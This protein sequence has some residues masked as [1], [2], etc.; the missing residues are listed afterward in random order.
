MSVV[1]EIKKGS[2][3]IKAAQLDR[4]TDISGRYFAEYNSS[5]GECKNPVAEPITNIVIT[6]NSTKVNADPD[7][8]NDYV[9]IEYI[10][11]KN[12]QYIDTGIGSFQDI[13]VTYQLVGDISEQKQYAKLLYNQAYPL[14][15]TYGVEVRTDSKTFT[16]VNNTN[17]IS[18]AYNN[19]KTNL[20]L[21]YRVKE[22]N[23]LELKLKWTIGASS[24]TANIRVYNVKFTNNADTLNGTAGKIDGDF[25]PVIR[26]S[27]NKPGM[28][29]KVSKQ[30]FVNQGT[31]EFVTGPELPGKILEVD[32]LT[33][34]G[35]NLL[36]ESL[37]KAGSNVGVNWTKEGNAIIIN[38]STTSQ[39][40]LIFTNV[41]DNIFDPNK[42][43][44][45]S[46]RVIG[47]TAIMGKGT[48]ITYSWALFNTA[49]TKYARNSIW[50]SKESLINE[51]IASTFRSFKGNLFNNDD[52]LYIMLQSWRVGTTF[53]NLK[54]VFQIEEAS[55]PSIY[56][57]YQQPE[58][59]DL[60]PIHGIG[61]L[62]DK[63]E[64]TR[65][66]EYNQLVKNGNLVENTNWYDNNSTHKINNSV[67]EST[68]TA[69]HGG[70]MQD[71]DA[72]KYREHKML[73]MLEGMIESN[74]NGSYFGIC[75]NDNFSQSV[76]PMPEK[77]NKWQ[78]LYAFGTI[79]KNANSS[80]TPLVKIQDPRSSN[81]TKRYARNIRVIDLTKLF[82][83]GNEPTT[84]E[85]FYS[86][87]IGKLIQKGVYLPYSETN[88]RISKVTR[89]R[90]ANKIDLGTFDYNL[91]TLDGNPGFVAKSVPPNMQIDDTSIND[92]GYKYDVLL[93][94]DR[95]FN[96]H[97][98]SGGPWFRND[99][100]TRDQQG[101]DDLKASLSGKY[102]LYK[103]LTP[104]YEDITD[105]ELGQNLLNLAPYQP[106][107]TEFEVNNDGTIEFGYW[108]Q[109]DP[110]PDTYTRVK[111][112]VSDGNQ[113]ITVSDIV[114]KNIWDEEWE[115]GEWEVTDGTP[116]DSA[117][118]IRCKNFIKVKPNTI[119]YHTIQLAYWFIMFD[120]NKQY[121]GYA[122]GSNH[123]T[124]SPDCY[125]IKFYCE[126]SYG[127]TYNHDIC[128]ME[129]T[130]GMDTSYAPYISTMQNNSLE[131]SEPKKTLFQNKDN[132][133]LSVDGYALKY[134]QLVG[135]QKE[136][137]D[138]GGIVWTFNN[139]KLSIKG[140]SSID[141]G[142]NHY[143]DFF[144]T[145]YTTIVGHKYMVISNFEMSGG[146][147]IEDL[148]TYS[149]KHGGKPHSGYVW[150]EDS[151]YR[152]LIG[153]NQNV[154]FV[155]NV[156]SAIFAIV[157]LTDMFGAGN[158][159]TTLDEFYATPQGKLYRGYVEY[160]YHILGAGEYKS[161]QLVDDELKQ[162]ITYDGITG[163]YDEGSHS[164]AFSGVSTSGSNFYF[165]RKLQLTKDHTYLIPLINL[166]GGGNI[167]IYSPHLTKLYIAEKKP[168]IFKSS[169]TTTALLYLNYGNAGIKVEGI[170]CPLIIDVTDL[171]L[172]H[173][174]LDELEVQRPDLFVYKPY[175]ETETRYGMILSDGRV[176]PLTGP[177]YGLNNVKD[178]GDTVG[179]E[180]KKYDYVDLGILNWSI[181]N[182]DVSSSVFVTHDLSDR[183]KPIDGNQI[184]NI[185][186]GKYETTRRADVVLGQY[187]K[188]IG[189]GAPGTVGTY[190]NICDLNYTD[191]SEFKKSLQ[192]LILV[193]EKTTPE[194]IDTALTSLED[195]TI[196]TNE[197]YTES[198]TPVEQWIAKYYSGT[199]AVLNYIPAVRNSDLKPGM[200][201]VATG[202]F[203]TNEGTGEFTYINDWTISEP[204]TLEVD[205]DK[206]EE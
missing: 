182:L 86:T 165:T 176:H 174:T 97:R 170:F 156:D 130:D 74:D 95:T 103:L 203:K 10:E 53:N 77:A 197:E 85:E 19:N 63:I 188:T 172:D 121:I 68:A 17:P 129:Y 101:C 98:G 198:F 87:P 57:P 142:R 191:A 135:Y 78:L 192:G 175:H 35:V 199:H 56:E 36:N 184:A 113:K 179:K 202:E 91:V 159:P 14:N 20:S 168:T 60:Q 64:V 90:V 48:D 39:S 140:T 92:A 69:K 44:V 70:V 133:V 166:T 62:K 28:Y 31:G 26:K 41:F 127:T 148:D 71:F 177:L 115:K 205:E 122:G 100:F 46:A 118:A 82:G 89:Y 114:G 149:I 200:Y 32:T 93:S 194:V 58:V 61:E 107:T 52:K 9:A 167:L 5:T 196:V 157:D 163:T 112:L 43:Y 204:A 34:H 38:G 154:G 73:C 169:D 119:Y 160:G 109:I 40:N 178:K 139:G 15:S 201:E 8:P 7:I 134:S 137:I 80:S 206:V 72:R 146:I 132:R 66:V 111:A 123:W 106:Y 108:R 84:L 49:G 96:T 88:N 45:F 42:Y 24:E 143:S 183:L 33:K 153:F 12:K 145:D 189:V 147:F 2:K 59:I 185:I 6:G 23:Y 22:P 13:E 76:L 79:N 171:G 144:R 81:W 67:I 99:A 164:Y 150:T 126:R 65:D 55:S 4:I 102:L 195:D 161:N 152:M 83:E 16:T 186:C 128:I 27:D 54:V 110:L 158:E 18:I 117:P 37:L 173:L 50:S 187:D 1:S 94:K 104:Y 25:Y 162:S 105:T 193:F 30:F 29:D 125:Y 47:G 51:N 131:M 136:S 116:D 141:G 155:M 3:K 124:T 75:L 11:L 190:L 180:T 181:N 151:S 120:V 138:I 21:S